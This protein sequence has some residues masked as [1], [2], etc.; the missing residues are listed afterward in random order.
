MSFDRQLTVAQL[1]LTHPV[2][3]QVFRAHKIDFCCGGE[4][5]V[6]VAAKQRGLVPSE[7]IAA[8]DQVIAA[9][10]ATG[11]EE[12]A[13]AAALSTPA[14]LDL[15]VER[16]HT[17]LRQTLPFLGSLAAKVA[18]VHGQKNP[19]LEALHE[20]FQELDESLIAHLEEEE[21]EL[22][23][24]L[25]SG[26][27]NPG[28]TKRELDAM[29]SEHLEVGALLSA[30][31]EAADEYSLPTWACASYRT[32]MSELESMEADLFRHIHLETHVLMPRFLQTASA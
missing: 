31:R 26:A 6:E 29:H 19:K 15:I 5:P 2:T 21:T 12:P 32:L 18:R 8:L 27:P 9:R 28:R 10:A 3:A 16:H 23:P 4:V 13:S 25:R 20:T 1:V 24:Y 30:L 7:V 11:E 14:L 17:Y 22:F